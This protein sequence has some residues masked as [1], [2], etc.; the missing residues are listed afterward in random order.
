MQPYHSGVIS[1]TTRT[2]G[3]TEETNKKLASLHRGPVRNAATTFER[4][5]VNRPVNDGELLPFASMRVG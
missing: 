4:L 1:A 5:Y 3:K 2:L